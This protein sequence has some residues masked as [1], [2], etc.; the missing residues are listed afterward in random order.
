VPVCTGVGTPTDD[1]RVLPE[2][3]A[4]E[5]ARFTRFATGC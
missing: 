1:G 4:V 2:V 3:A 5:L